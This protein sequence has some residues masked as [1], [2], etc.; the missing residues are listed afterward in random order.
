MEI[1]PIHFAEILAA[2]RLLSEYAAECSIPEIGQICPQPEMYAAME[3]MGIVRVSGV[4]AGRSL[5]GFSSVI[6]SVL[7]HYGRKTAT[8]E[9]MFIEKESRRGGAG[10]K[11]M[12]A[13]EQDGTQNACG[14]A[15]YSAPAGSQLEKMLSMQEK[16]RRVS[17][18]FVRRLA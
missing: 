1:R 9:S 6:H 3:R 17:S 4:F 15:L 2:D 18:I 11:L 16:Y 5:V 7:P 12:E 10:L 14:S 8:L 13:I